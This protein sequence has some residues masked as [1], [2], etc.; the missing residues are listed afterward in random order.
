MNRISRY[1]TPTFIGLTTIL[2]ILFAWLYMW[3]AKYELSQSSSLYLLNSFFKSLAYSSFGLTICLLITL[4]FFYGIKHLKISTIN[5]L[6]ILLILQLQIGIIPKLYAY[7]GV[8]SFSGFWGWIF[9]TESPFSYSFLG[10]GLSLFY[11]Y[12]PFYFIPLLVAI[13]EKDNYIKS[14]IILK[15]NNLDLLNLLLKINRNAIF[16]SGILFI[17]LSLMDFTCS[18]LVGGG[19]YDTYGKAIYRT[20]ITFRDGFTALTFGI[21]VLIMIIG[22][23]SLRKND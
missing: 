10:I 21:A 14:A 6:M 17:A 11:I 19:K 9:N 20:A 12:S 8:Y 16:F 13:K 18:D 2:P 15:A 7:L 22:I 4:L 23:L 1:I 5:F 3:V